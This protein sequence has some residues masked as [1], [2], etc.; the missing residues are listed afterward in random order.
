LLHDGPAVILPTTAVGQISE[1]ITLGVL[2]EGRVQLGGFS[3]SLTGDHPEDFDFDDML[4]D[5]EFRNFAEVAVRFQPQAEGLRRATLQITSNDPNESPFLVNLEALAELD[6]C[7]ACAVVT[8]LDQAGYPKP[9][10]KWNQLVH[11]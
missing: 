9:F 1:T 2:N 10:S 8:E 7:P 5:L 11:T 6:D 4:I 3:V